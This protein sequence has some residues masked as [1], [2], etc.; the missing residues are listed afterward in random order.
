MNK[1][2]ND[3]YQWIPVKIMRVRQQLVGG[4]KYMLS[5]LVAQSN[6]TKKVSFNLASNG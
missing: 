4:V 2:S 3:V 1:A 5:I 6:C